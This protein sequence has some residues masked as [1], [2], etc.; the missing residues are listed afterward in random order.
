MKRIAPW[1]ISGETGARTL[2]SII[3]RAA[4]RPLSAE[5][6]RAVGSTGRIATIEWV[7]TSRS[8]RCE[9]QG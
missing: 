5:R 2:P 1:R 4:A 3:S 7:E 8:N 9:P 6:K